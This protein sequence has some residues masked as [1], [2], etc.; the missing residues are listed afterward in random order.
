MEEG[1]CASSLSGSADVATVHHK[2]A[3]KRHGRPVGRLQLNATALIDVVFLLLVYFLVTAN[4][5]PDE[6]VLT[7][8]LPQGLGVPADALS[9]PPTPIQIGLEAV[10][11][12]GCQ[13]HLDDEIVG[14]FKDLG[15][16]LASRQYDP[17]RGRTEG[18][19]KPD[20]PIVITPGATVRWQHV[21][22]AFN[23]AVAARYTHVSFAPP[24]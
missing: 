3:R 23:A 15:R 5:A 13:I 24:Q 6:G 2:T 1:F 4:F 20:N 12:V 17:G 22:N 10:G 14:S 19:Y 7:A 8:K 11:D 18:I 16:V 9:L 21:A